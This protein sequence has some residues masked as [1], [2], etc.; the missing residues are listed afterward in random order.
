MHHHYNDIRSLILQDPAW[1]DENGVPRYGKF[2]PDKLSDI[3]ATEAALVR[4]CCQA[5]HEEFDVA[6]SWSVIRWLNQPSEIFPE[7]PIAEQIK[8][9][10]LHYGDP[11]NVGCC[12]SGPTMNCED[13]YVLQYWRKKSVEWVRDP[14][15]EV[16]LEGAG[17]K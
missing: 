16:S 5:C 10:T 6:F 12:P 17:G 9:K 1:W 2:Q 11:P 8:A 14:G 4:I 7:A 15:L 13:R 3:Y